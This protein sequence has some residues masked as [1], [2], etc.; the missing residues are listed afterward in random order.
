MVCSFNALPSSGHGTL[1]S[2]NT[3]AIRSR[4]TGCFTILYRRHRHYCT[5]PL[6]GL[7]LANAWNTPCLGGTMRNWRLCMGWTRGPNPRAQSYTSQRPR[8]IS[9][10]FYHLP[11]DRQRRIFCGYSDAVYF[12][13]RNIHHSSWPLLVA[14][15]VKHRNSCNE[16]DMS[17]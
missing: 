2:L 3:Q 8:P 6:C 10:Q 11:N 16:L 5:C 7:D 17:N 1:P 15:W 9:I 12:N 14:F 4:Q 13:R